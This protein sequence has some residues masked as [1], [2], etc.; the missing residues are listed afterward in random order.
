MR[1]FYTKVY[2]VSF[3]NPDGSDRQ[4]ILAQLD[5]TYDDGGFP[6][7]LKRESDNPH[8]AMAIAVIAP[9]GQQLGYLSRSVANNV[10]PLI[11][12]GSTVE[13]SATQITGGWPYHYGVNIQVTIC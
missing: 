10:A 1:S 3:Q 12:G 2:G 4:N 8:D 13:A 7:Q 5:E 9:T 11:D 6:L